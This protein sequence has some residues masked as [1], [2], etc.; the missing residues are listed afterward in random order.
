MNEPKWIAFRL[1]PAQPRGGGRTQRWDVVTKG[2]SEK[3]V[4]GIVIGH[5]SW[6]GAWRKYAF[7]PNAGTLFEEDCLR[8]IATFLGQRMADRRG[9]G[10]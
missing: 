4:G 7:F 10:A 2:G 3:E 9:A 1:S 8:D 5:V 6:W